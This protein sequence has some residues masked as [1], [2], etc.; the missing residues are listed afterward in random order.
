MN[1]HIPHIAIGLLICALG[2]SPRAQSPTIDPV[3][4]DKA[5]ANSYKMIDA[6]PKD[7]KP[8]QDLGLAMYQKGDL[9]GA[10]ES[11]K[12]ALQLKPDDPKTHLYM[13]MVLE[14][15][16]QSDNALKAYAAGLRSNPKG[17]TG[18]AIRAR[19]SFLS[20]Q[21]LKAQASDVV[22]KEKSINVESFPEK[23][24]A[25][26]NF[27]G[28]TL[29]PDLAPLS[30]GLAEMTS[31]DLSKVHE[32]T[33]IE[34]SKLDFIMQELK[35]SEN[36]MVDQATA[37]RMGKLLGSK[38]V[39]TGSLVGAGPERI[40]LDGGIV[41]T[42]DGEFTPTGANEGELKSF[43]KVQKEFV[44]GV[45]DKAGVKPTPEE[46]TEIEKVPTESYVAFLAYSRGLDFQRRGMPNEAL[47]AFQSAVKAD[48]SFKE[49]A[50]QSDMLGARLAPG[51]AY[52]SDFGS[53][54]EQILDDASSTG[55]LGDVDYRLFEIV[56]DNGM[57]PHNTPVPPI[58][59]P[60]VAGKT[61]VI[62]HGGAHGDK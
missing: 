61:T 33:V 50:S 20:E 29:P 48:G 51:N 26:V 16:N 52:A 3:A 25:V 31:N 11:L 21:R 55:K 32:L 58:K 5:I 22:Q 45:L 7:Q 24:I 12:R 37:P 1:R 30:L 23:S 13:G 28:S 62:V 18:S 59:P 44:F 14:K 43:F 42:G 60:F 54:E 36:G 19:L 6:H 10:E 57:I 47:G 41:S 15:Q 2:G 17:K 49:A 27:D 40:H 4:L 8:W 35:L 56:I 9:S 46:R 39:V 38:Q 34:R 53:F